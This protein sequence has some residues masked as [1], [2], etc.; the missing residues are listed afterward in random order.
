MHQRGQVDQLDDGRDASRARRWCCRWPRPRAA[1][2]PPR[3]CLPW[4]R[5][6]WSVMSRTAPDASISCVAQH[7]LHARHAAP[8]TGAST[9]AR[10]LRAAQARGR[11][12][13][14]CPPRA[15]ARQLVGGV[16]VEGAARSG[17]V[18]AQLADAA[19]RD[20]RPA[21]RGS[22]IRRRWPASSAARAGTAHAR[23]V[24][25]VGRPGCR[26]RAP[27][28]AGVEA[29][30]R[31]RARAGAPSTLG[32]GR[33]ACRRPAR[34]PTRSPAA[35]RGLQARGRGRPAGRR[36]PADRQST[37]SRPELGVARL[38]GAAGQDDAG[39][40][41]TCVER[42]PGRGSRRRPALELDAAPCRVPMRS[43][44]TAAQQDAD[45]LRRQRGA[46]AFSR[47]TCTGARPARIPRF[48][49]SSFLAVA[50][51]R[52]VPLGQLAGLRR[53]P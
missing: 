8:S 12:S 43:A 2:G 26:A 16:H 33:A 27:S 36:R 13:R 38:R 42:P 35:R 39:M 24:D 47:C 37:S 53:T 30:P 20:P 40:P 46:L 5:P 34:P 29:A 49:D 3:S 7:A 4:K 9:W 25:G 18:R 45:H 41:A 23:V 11:G 15:T 6:T 52:L 10:G 51:G 21:R 22:S 48:P 17:G 44:P 31:A 50:L 1:P 14:R 19:A 28:Q 32:V